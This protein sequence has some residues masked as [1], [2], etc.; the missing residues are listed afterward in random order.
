MALAAIIR[1]AGGE[2]RT[3]ADVE[4]ILVSEGRASA[5]RLATGETIPA[6][7]AVLACVTPTQL[8]GRLL[9]DGEVP[10]ARARGGAAVPLRPRRDADPHRARRSRRAGR[11]DERLARTSR[12][13]TSRPGL[14]G[15]SRAVNEAERGLLPAEAT[16][17]LG[18]PMARRPVAR[19]GRLVGHLDP[20]AGAARRGRRA[21]RPERS[22]PATAPGPRSCARPTPTGSWRGSAGT[23]RT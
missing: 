23:S 2:L 14:D 5:V 3:E 8:Y 15:V 22:T 10:A 18:Q 19:A 6:S 12:S 20:A 7:R 11:G 16:I 17:A 13:S 21:T 9:A 1:D 4:R